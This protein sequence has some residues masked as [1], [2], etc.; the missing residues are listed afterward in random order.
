MLTLSASPTTS[1]MAAARCGARDPPTRRPSLLFGRG[2]IRS[3]PGPSDSWESTTVLPSP[4]VVPP[5]SDALPPAPLQ[6]RGQTV[7][8]AIDG[9]VRQWGFWYLGNWVPLFGP[10]CQTPDHRT[11]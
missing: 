11:S 3:R 6:Y 9:G 1:I 4:C 10:E 2:P 8:P 5:S 7:T